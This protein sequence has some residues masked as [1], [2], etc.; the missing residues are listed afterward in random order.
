MTARALASLPEPDGK[1]QARRE[2]FLREFSVTANHRRLQAVLDDLPTTPNPALAPVMERV[3]SHL[4][5]FPRGL[6]GLANSGSEL[7]HD[8]A[9]RFR[10]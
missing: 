3:L 7:T 4:S 6:L 1:Q 10:R 9:T 5:G 8:S 2:L